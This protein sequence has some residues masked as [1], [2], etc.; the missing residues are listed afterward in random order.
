MK[1][2]EEYSILLRW[3]PCING[4]EATVP[5]LPGISVAGKTEAKA[6][7][8]ARRA[9]AAFLRMKAAWEGEGKEG[10][11]HNVEHHQRRSTEERS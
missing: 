11:F 4:Y 10:H 9:I 7:A 5:E 6:V 3:H 8:K 1:N 2:P